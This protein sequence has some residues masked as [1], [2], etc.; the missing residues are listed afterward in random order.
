[1]LTGILKHGSTY[2]HDPT[3]YW[4][5]VGALEYISSR[6]DIGY[7]VNKVYQFMAQVLYWNMIKLSKEYFDI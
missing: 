2:K 7:N 6:P 4:S 3:L 5:I 1:M